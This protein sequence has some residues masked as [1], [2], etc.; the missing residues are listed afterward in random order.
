MG[1]AG[2]G[3]RDI[4]IENL[5][6]DKDDVGHPRWMKASGEDG[7]RARFTIKLEENA[8]GYLVKKWNDLNITVAGETV[9]AELS[10]TK[11]GGSAKRG[12]RRPNNPDMKRAKLSPEPKLSPE[13]Y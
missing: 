12:R 2:E 3:I 9:K 4:L 7:F 13:E 1:Q 6:L 8:I 11:E 10:S 5:H